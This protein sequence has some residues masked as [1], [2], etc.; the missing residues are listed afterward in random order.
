MEFEPLYTA[1]GF[2][3]NEL[4]QN[5][6]S[7][8]LPQCIDRE[9]GG[10]LNC[11]SNDGTRLVSHDKYTWS[12]GR[13]V[14]CFSRLAVMDAPTFTSKQ[15]AGFLE[16]AKNGAAFLMQ[17]CLMGEDD[18]RCVFLRLKRARRSI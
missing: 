1:Y 10:F 11:F 2:Y 5:I 7:F 14:W 13:F 15:R 16:L 6:L 12:Q 4:Q 8:W 9:Y 18:W 17:H 3:E